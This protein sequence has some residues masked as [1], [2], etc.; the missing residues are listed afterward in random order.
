M[1]RVQT[2]GYSIVARWLVTAS[3]RLRSPISRSSKNPSWVML[4]IRFSNA[5]LRAGRLLD[6]F[7]L[8]AENERLV[9]ECL[10]TR[11]Q[12]RLAKELNAFPDGDGTD[13]GYA[14]RL[15]LTG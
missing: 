4:S 1:C 11:P 9:A 10:E 5:A 8:P 7:V 3:S 14:A 6:L 12:W 2:R 13:G 15:E